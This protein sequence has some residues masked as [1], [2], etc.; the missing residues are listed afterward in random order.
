MPS[1][2]PLYDSHLFVAISKNA[3]IIFVAIAQKEIVSIY[4]KRDFNTV[5]CQFLENIFHPFETLS[6]QH[7]FMFFTAYLKNLVRPPSPVEIPA[8]FRLIL[9]DLIRQDVLVIAMIGFQ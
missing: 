6:T 9:S 4:K 7:S 3:R 5:L 8:A 1:A 2:L